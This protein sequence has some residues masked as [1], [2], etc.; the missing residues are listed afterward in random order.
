MTLSAN[1]TSYAFYVLCFLLLISSGCASLPANTER[2]FS[3]SL[4]DTAST[5]MGRYA[6][7]IGSLYPKKCGFYLL[8]N[9]QDALVARGQLADLAERSLD[10]QYY[11]FHDDLVGGLLAYKLLQAADRGVRV[12]LLLDDMGLD[13]RD[14]EI[15]M[16]DRHP[17][18][19]IR[20]FNP[21]TR[22][23]MRTVQLLTR[24]GSVT[25]RMHNKTFIADNSAAILGGRNIGNEYFGNDPDLAFGDLD[26]LTIGT[27]VKQVSTSFDQYWNSELS[28]PVSNLTGKISQGE[29]AET[30]AHWDK[31]WNL[32]KD[33]DYAEALRNS[34]LFQKILNNEVTL[35]FGTAKVLA[36]KPEKI[37]KE[38]Q[39][40]SYFLAPQ[41]VKYLKKTQHELIIL[42][43]YFVPGK[44]GVAFLRSLVKQG[45]RVRILTNSLSSNDVILVHAGYARY[46]RDLL[47][48]GI[49]LYEI[50][51]KM[52]H[53]DRKEKKGASGSTGKASLHA[54][55]FILDRE[56]VFISSFNFD[57]RSV[58]ENT[59][60]G[61]MIDAP[62]LA[63]PMAEEFD[64]K[65]NKLSF[66]LELT[67]EEDGI[68][69]IKWVNDKDGEQIVYKN[70]PYSS[71]WQR[72]LLFLAGSLP[73]E[74]QL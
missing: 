21:F 52:S 73:I 7:K 29:L 10:I 57:P 28:Y 5:E 42:S 26:V 63:R 54:K 14:Q 62:D 24:F 3:T 66:Q 43:A 65:I 30:R 12:R 50:D 74:S 70:D 56:K 64:E 9:G 16:L 34:T 68:E 58:L 61:I 17:N 49:E 59:E 39:D 44:E 55:T 1:K 41:L 25:R 22:G 6:D 48:A 27:V 71:I 33:S 13:N 23:I 35:N 53:R 11:L 67:T 36:D 69:L 40:R 8:G 72:M 15:A 2:T 47:R 32:K 20:I 4:K 38:E 46:R 45:V 19:E 31:M 18:I 60:I 51:K 37:S